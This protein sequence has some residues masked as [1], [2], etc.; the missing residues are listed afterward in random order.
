MIEAVA[1]DVDHLQ[2]AARQE[3]HLHR[4]DIPEPAK[5]LLLEPVLPIF[6]QGFKLNALCKLGAAQEIAVAVRHGAQ[7]LIGT[8]LLDIGLHKRRVRAEL[9]D[10]RVFLR[11]DFVDNLIQRVRILR[12]LGRQRHGAERQD[13]QKQ[14]QSFHFASG[15]WLERNLEF[16]VNGGWKIHRFA[17]LKRRLEANLLSSLDGLLVETVPEAFGDANNLYG[18]AGG[19]DHLNQHVT[20]DAQFAG[21]FGVLRLGLV[22][23]DD[24]GHSGLRVGLFRLWRCSVRCGG[25]ESASLNIA[26]SRAG[27]SGSNR[28]AVAETGTRHGAADAISAARSVA[29]ARTRGKCWRAKMP[30]IGSAVRIARTRQAVR[31][32]EPAG[33]NLI[34]RFVDSRGSSAAGR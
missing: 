29:I 1:I 7:C 19:E 8:H 17:V 21:F 31:I 14:L 16:D 33:L 15:N 20:L 5:D 6:G 30:D 10:I 23:D 22:Q 25:L 13:C 9:F 2:E 28:H 34:N 27:G 24:L 3:V 11:H 26:R 12:C 18:A 32:A 4:E